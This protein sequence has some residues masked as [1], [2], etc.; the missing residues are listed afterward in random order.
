MHDAV[1][2]AVTGKFTEPSQEGYNPHPHKVPLSTAMDMLR[3]EASKLGLQG[4][5][6]LTT[7]KSERVIFPEHRS[8]VVA[9]S[10]TYTPDEAAAILKKAAQE[11]IAKFEAD[12]RDLRSRELKKAIVPPHKHTTGTTSSAGIEDV[13]PG[14]L[15][16]PGIDKAEGGA[17]RCTCKC[18]CNQRLE[19]YAPGDKTCGACADVCKAPDKA[20]STLFEDPEPK[21]LHPSDKKKVKKAD[22]DAHSSPQS[23]PKAPEGMD[24]KKIH[25]GEEGDIA[26]MQAHSAQ[27]RSKAGMPS[28]PAPGP[29][30]ADVTQHP[31]FKPQSQHPAY[32]DGY[33]RHFK[34]AL[35]ETPQWAHKIAH[36][37]GEMAMERASGVHKSE[38]IGKEELC[39]GCGKSHAGA[40]MD[41][42]DSMPGDSCSKCDGKGH[43]WH[44]GEAGPHSDKKITCTRCKGSGEQP[45]RKGDGKIKPNQLTDVPA[46]QIKRYDGAGKQI[47]KAMLKDAKGKEKD[48]GIVDGSTLPDDKNAEHVNKPGTTS[49]TAGSGGHIKKGKTLASLH[50]GILKSEPPMA[51][52]PSGKAPGTMTPVSKPAAMAKPAGG[53]PAQP[54]VKNELEKGDF[55]MGDSG[56]VATSAA[57]AA[58]I[59]PKLPKKPAYGAAN[60]AAGKAALSAQGITPKP[61]LP[62][63]PGLVSPKAAGI[64]ASPTPN[65][66][67]SPSLAPKKPGIFGRLMGKK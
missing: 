40:C 56:K 59:K 31:N 23:E 60:L 55:G 61:T 4:A 5:H 67:P 41:K 57:Q 47:E 25:K 63:K 14:K 34:M 39:K 35:G 28:R 46:H 21:V 42:S 7:N 24:V 10:K 49:K 27:V 50:K 12:L 32:L 15:N 22:K 18:G 1:H 2:R 58:P 53:T 13:A 19:G 51:K 33:Q 6:H 52:P 9:D 26:H 65:P 62:T 17:A 29:V 38:E 30:P 64:A 37:G 48:N 11:K 66:T 44:S 16:P 36:A 8:Y 45:G 54:T 20:T 43:I 3:E